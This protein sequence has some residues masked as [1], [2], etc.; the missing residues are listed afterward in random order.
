MRGREALIVMGKVPRA[1]KVK[2]R[3]SPRLSPESAC[4]LYAA[5]LADTVREIGRLRAPEKYLFH[6]PPSAGRS[7]AGP[8]FRE[9]RL[10][11]QRGGDL[12]ERM[13]HAVRVAARRGASLAVVVGADC[14][15]LSAGR[16]REAFR[17]LRDGADAVLGPTVDGGFYLVGIPA[18]RPL[19]VSGVAWSTPTALRDVLADCR[20]RG[21]SFSLLPTAFDVDTPTDLERL[22]AWARARPRPACPATRAWLAR[23]LPG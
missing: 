22:R 4:A 17:E 12:G 7:F 11:P 16:L 21:L 13:A 23:V 9:F 8:H 20:A 19:P 5:L 14:P 15:A 2:T 1:G 3:L 6:S 10:L 18:D